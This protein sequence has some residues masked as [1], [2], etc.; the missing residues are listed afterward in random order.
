MKCEKC[1]NENSIED[2][3]CTKCGEKLTSNEL[4]ELPSKKEITVDAE[5]N[6]E[7][8]VEEV[9]EK[10]EEK[11]KDNDETIVE[12]DIEELET[13]EEE[14]KEDIVQ[15]QPTED[16]KE[17]QTVPKKKTNYFQYVAIILIVS[18]IVGGIVYFSMSVS[19][20]KYQELS[21]KNST[22]NEVKLAGFTYKIP[23]EYS[24]EKGSE[25]ISITDKDESWIIQLGSTKA[26]Y[27]LLKNNKALLQSTFKN[28]GIIAS[29]PTI[30]NIKDK[31]YLTLEL[32]EN[33]KKSLVAYSKFNSMYINV[34][35]VRNTSNNYDYDKLDIANKIINDATFNDEELNVEDK[36]FNIDDIIETTNKT[37]QN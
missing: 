28:D 10:D 6:V 16:K 7:N 26:S 31:E 37:I 23:Q 13:K 20:K 27:D 29:V 34:V 14:N 24:Y 25:Y 19:L 4:Q 18:L 2:K 33:S 11:T 36:T 1:G 5:E 12:D 30:K 22:Y 17:E 8:N 32:N 35:L 3:Y 21:I 15:E 9:E